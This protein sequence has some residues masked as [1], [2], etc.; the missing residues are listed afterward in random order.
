MCSVLKGLKLFDSLPVFVNL[1]F[2][3]QSG[4]PVRRA[5]G[6]ARGLLL[7]VPLGGEGRRRRRLEQGEQEARAR[8]LPDNWL[9]SG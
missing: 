3:V 7:V 9:L 8:I 4:T 5:G 1:R 2:Y 6:G